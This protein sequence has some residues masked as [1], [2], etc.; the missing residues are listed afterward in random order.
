MKLSVY[1]EVWDVP[2]ARK[3]LL[4]GPLVRAP[5]FGSSFVLTLHVVDHL[6]RS[7]AEA[8]VVSA[9]ATLAIALAG[10]WRG[11][12]LDRHGVRRTLAPSLVLLPLCWAIAPFVGYWPLL[13]LVIV[14]G[15]F[16]VP[17]FSIMRQGMV[18][19][20]PL[21]LRGPGLALESVSVELSFMSGPALA[22]AAATLWGTQT[23]LLVCNLISVA[24]ACLIAYVNPRTAT[25]SE[26]AHPEQPTGTW[27]SIPVIGVMAVALAT[28]AALGAT[29]LSVVAGLKSLGAPL[30]IGWVLTVWGA[31]SALGGFFYG[32]SQY[33]LRPSHLLLGLGLLTAPVALATTSWQMAVLLFFQGL[34]ISTTI[35]SMTTELSL[36]VPERAR[37]EAFGWHG[38]M[39]TSGSALSAPLIGGAID[40][41][42]W[43]AGFASG[44]AVAVVLALAVTFIAVRRGRRQA[45]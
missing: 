42:G 16:N 19:A 26:D 43:R 36:L 1:R 5:L 38:S 39:L 9:V 15:F 17:T 22:V 23:T 34:F 8:G 28:A 18:T 45:S 10:P 13:A 27:W 4:L 40:G 35:T 41:W 2:A 6:G 14:A 12:V 44:G 32:A 21:P 31:G 11:R 20:L 7:W 33:Q 3:L 29:D 24:G 37:G 25:K 30:A